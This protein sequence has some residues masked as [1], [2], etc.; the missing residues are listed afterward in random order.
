NSSSGCAL[1]AIAPSLISSWPSVATGRRRRGILNR[2][3][4]GSSSRVIG[5][6]VSPETSGPTHFVSPKRASNGTLTAAAAIYRTRD[7]AHRCPSLVM[8]AGEADGGGL[9][10]TGTGS[11]GRWLCGASFDA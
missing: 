7:R 11:A 8:F 10:S 2:R 3:D 4:H 6:S 5:P 1:H 9:T